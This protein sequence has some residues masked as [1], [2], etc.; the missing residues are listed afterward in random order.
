[1]F[2]LFLFSFFFFGK[3]CF[4]NKNLEKSGCLFGFIL[5]AGKVLTDGLIKYSLNMTHP[6]LGTVLVR[7]LFFF[8][9]Y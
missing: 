8:L 3:F 2:V 7:L 9:D 6:G 4:H 1:M 5:I